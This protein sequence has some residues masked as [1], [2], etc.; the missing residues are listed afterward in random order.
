M[1]LIFRE[2]HISE[3]RSVE[4]H[5]IIERCLNTENDLH[6]HGS[7]TQDDNGIRDDDMEVGLVLH[8]GRRW[9]TVISACR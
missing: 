3:E 4:K 6:N 8:I 7:P 2:Q 1:A 5:I 9:F